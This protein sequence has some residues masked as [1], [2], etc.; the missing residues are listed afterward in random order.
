MPGW[1]LALSAAWAGEWRDPKPY[2][3]PVLNVGVVVV[4]GFTAA[5]AS[6]GAIGGVRV[7]YSDKP[8]WV[9]HTRASVI[10]S[11]GLNTGSLGA[12]LR[13]GSFIGPDWKVVQYQVGPDAWYNGYG[14]IDAEDYWLPWSPG[15][16]LRNVV[17]LKFAPELHVVGEATPGWAFVTDRQTG[18]VDPFHELTLAAM[19]VIRAPFARLTIGY[20]RQYRSFGMSEG[21]ILSGAL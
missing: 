11:Y 2:V 21:L 7:R 19:L 14:R 16:D 15:V 12:D 17:T 9:S 13:L 8:H 1:W 18:D 4:D 3:L 5:Q 10:G 6:A 20:S